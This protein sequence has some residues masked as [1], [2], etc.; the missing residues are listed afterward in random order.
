MQATAEA[1]ALIVG[2]YI[3]SLRSALDHLAWALVTVAN[4]RTLS[5][6]HER[7]IA[8][9][10]ISTHP[11]DFW[12]TVTVGHLTLEQGLVLESFQPY[13]AIG[14][15]KT[16]PLADLNALWNLDKHRLLTPIKVSLSGEVG[17]VFSATDAQI[18]GEPKWDPEV[19][20]VDGTDV[21]W[22]T[23]EPT[24][25]NPKVNMDRFSVDVTFGERDRLITDLPTL[26]YLTTHIVES[27]AHFFPQPDN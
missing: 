24:G 10:V 27:C 12:G 25:P 5:K 4:K 22:V 6:E 13:R 26:M 23:A 15:E 9:P 19:T 8:F 1:F 3:H 14:M 18:V 16:T 2:D 17:P 7:Q 11:K 21:A 20:L